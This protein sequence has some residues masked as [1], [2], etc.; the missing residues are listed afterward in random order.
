VNWFLR[1]VGCVGVVCC[2]V[3]A[4]CGPSGTNT[5]PVRG[6]LTIDGQ[7]AD[8]VM[9][10]LAPLD[11]SMPVATGR[12]SNGSFE[13]YSGVQGSPGAVPG[14]YK[15]VLAPSE[16]TSVDAAK[17]RYA[18]GVKGAKGGTVAPDADTALS[19]PEKYASSA[20]SD[21]EVEITSG[22]NDLEIAL[23]R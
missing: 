4:G 5:V 18:G 2:A 7:P 8:N 1:G 16:A 12:V 20:T 19:F 22:Q 3:L 6:T 13:L 9:I 11:T 10:T 21:Y 14:K 23:T 15:V 17:A